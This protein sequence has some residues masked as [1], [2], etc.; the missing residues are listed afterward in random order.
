[1]SDIGFAHDIAANKIAELRGLLKANSQFDVFN[2]ECAAV[3][4]S[5]GVFCTHCTENHNTIH[6][7]RAKRTLFVA[8]NGGYPQNSRLRAQSKPRCAINQNRASRAI[9]GALR[10]IKAALRA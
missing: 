4:R 9:K 6:D 7:E 5:G 1:M 8:P 2:S 10:A 3:L